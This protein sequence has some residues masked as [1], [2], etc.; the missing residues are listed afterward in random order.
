VRRQDN[1]ANNTGGGN[2]A[3]KRYHFLASPDGINWFQQS[4][5]ITAAGLASNPL[6]IG[7][8][9]LDIGL[10]FH[11]YGNTPTALTGT[12]TVDDFTLD[13][14]GTP[15][16]PCGSTGSNTCTWNVNSAGDWN[17][18][19]NWAGTATAATSVAPG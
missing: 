4:T 12:G 3:L 17:S 15:T 19:G 9:A 13:Y 1:G 14:V 2:P 7:N 6:N 8:V 11:T 10:S 5:A 18:T 16:Q